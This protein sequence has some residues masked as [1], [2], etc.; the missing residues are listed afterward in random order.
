MGVREWWSSVLIRK[1]DLSDQDMIDENGVINRA[2]R[3][4]EPEE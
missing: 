3:P 2:A 1:Y 4:S